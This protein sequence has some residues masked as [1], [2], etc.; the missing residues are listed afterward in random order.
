MPNERD[1]KSKT[2]KQRD[3]SGKEIPPQPVLERMGAEPG[4]G[5]NTPAGPNTRRE[6]TAAKRNRRKHGT[7]SPHEPERATG[8]SP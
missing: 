3:T 8:E 4:A 2:V 1:P 7:E 6:T 5:S